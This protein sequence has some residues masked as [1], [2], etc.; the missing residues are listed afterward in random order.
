M[1]LLRVHLPCFVYFRKKSGPECEP[2]DFMARAELQKLCEKGEICHDDQEEMKSF[3]RMYV[4]KEQYVLY[5][6]HYLQNPKWVK[7]MRK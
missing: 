2:N 3:S 5:C 6:L 1:N 4:V 7:I